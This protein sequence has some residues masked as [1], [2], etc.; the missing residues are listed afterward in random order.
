MSPRVI[1]SAS[2]ILA[3]GP[4]VSEIDLDSLGELNVGV[5]AKTKVSKD[6][7]PDMRAS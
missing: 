7:V 1:S 5:Y 3:L 6:A 4:T 2:L